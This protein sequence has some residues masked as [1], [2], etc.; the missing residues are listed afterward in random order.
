MAAY[1]ET[2]LFPFQ[3]SHGLNLGSLNS[4]GVFVPVLPVFEQHS[5]GAARKVESEAL[6][7]LQSSVVESPLVLSGADAAKFLDEQKRSLRQKCGTLANMFPDGGKLITV[8]EANLVVAVR[9][10]GSRWCC[11]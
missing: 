9:E 8:A 11:A 5:A 6:V 1:F 7:V 2:D 4:N 3:V 10:V